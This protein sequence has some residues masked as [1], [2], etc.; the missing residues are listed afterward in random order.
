M[1][2]LFRLPITVDSDHDGGQKKG[3]YGWLTAALLALG[4]WEQVTC[5]QG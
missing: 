4:T 5:V 1:G 2:L 3:G